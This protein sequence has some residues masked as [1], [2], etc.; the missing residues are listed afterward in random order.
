MII[1]KAA[2]TTRKSM[3]ENV[4]MLD[5]DFL[6]QKQKALISIQLIQL[7]SLIIDDNS[8]SNEAEK[9]TQTQMIKVDLSQLI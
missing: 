2:K 8:L 9:C 4:E 3:F 5:G 7:T 1:S 6:F